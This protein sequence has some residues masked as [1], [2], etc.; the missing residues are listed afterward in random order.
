MRASKRPPRLH[1]RKFGR[2]KT[3]AGAV[4]CLLFEQST[5][6]HKIRAIQATHPPGYPQIL[7]IRQT[8]RH[9]DGKIWGSGLDPQIK[10]LIT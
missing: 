3:G 7:G 10:Q 1:V 6:L 8:C 2:L 9:L 4:L 5:D